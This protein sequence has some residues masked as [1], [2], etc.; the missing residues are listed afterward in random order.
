MSDLILKHQ[1][2]DFGAFLPSRIRAQEL[3]SPQTR[4]S[5]LSWTFAPSRV[6]TAYASDPRPSP[7]EGCDSLRL[8]AKLGKKGPCDPLS[9][10]KLVGNRF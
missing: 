4:A 6:F 7:P 10:V 1:F 8:T 9:R 2:T 3:E 5:L